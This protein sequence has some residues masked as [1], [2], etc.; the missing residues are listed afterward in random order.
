M[1]ASVLFKSNMLLLCQSLY[2]IKYR[3]RKK[4]KEQGIIGHEHNIRNRAINVKLQK[5]IV[6]LTGQIVCTRW[7]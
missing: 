7:F 5:C 3:P 2:V 1:S 6:T 4:K